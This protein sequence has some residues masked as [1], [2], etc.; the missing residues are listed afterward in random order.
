[1]NSEKL[2]STQ[3]EEDTSESGARGQYAW[4]KISEYYPNTHNFLRP[5]SL[6]FVVSSCLWLK[7]SLFWREGKVVPGHCFS[8]LKKKC[9]FQVAQMKSWAEAG[10]QDSCPQ[11]RV[12]EKTY[13]ESIQISQ[14]S[15][16]QCE[17]GRWPRQIYTAQGSKSWFWETSQLRTSTLGPQG[18]K[19]RPI[20][21]KYWCY[22]A[23]FSTCQGKGNS[24]DKREPKS[25]YNHVFSGFELS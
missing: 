8:A 12:L 3:G 9:L 24:K 19:A 21:P 1:M 14:E 7:C 15:D 11:G 2:Y 6:M 22:Q 4:L 16:A 17:E 23:L 18:S 5:F 13:P 10:R 20:K 25:F